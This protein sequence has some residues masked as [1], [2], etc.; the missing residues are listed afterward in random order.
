MSQKTFPDPNVSHISTAIACPQ[1]HA[2]TAPHSPSFTTTPTSWTAISWER[3]TRAM[4]S[5]HTAK[6]MGHLFLRPGK[7][8]WKWG[9]GSFVIKQ[10]HDTAALS[11]LLWLSLAPGFN[12]LGIWGALAAPI[13]Q[14]QQHRSA[15]SGTRAAKLCFRLLPHPSAPVLP[16][17]P[18]LP[19][20]CSPPLS[21]VPFNYQLLLCSL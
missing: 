20:S 3:D 13:S 8:S 4:P 10:H 17:L 7:S 14:I 21:L 5:G 12:S 11:R 16:P 9:E 1:I 18:L 6:I 19:P 15:C 2:I